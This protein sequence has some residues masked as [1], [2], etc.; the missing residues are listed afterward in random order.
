M[1]HKLA[2]N[3]LNDLPSSVEIPRYDRAALSPGI[4]HIGVGNF[5]RAHQAVYLNKLI[6][7]DPGSSDWALV[8]AGVRAPDAKM[9]DLLSD[10]NWLYSVVEVDGDDHKASIVGAMIDF[11]AVEPDGNAPLVAAMSDPSIRI[12]S[13]TVTEGGYFLD[14]E[15]KFDATETSV[16]HDIANPE[17]PNTAFGAILAALRAR[18][19][20]GHGPFTVMSCDNLPGNGDIAREA[21][22]QMA[23]AQDASFGA[24][25]DENVTFPNGMVDRI[26][27]ATGPRERKALVDEF[28][29]EDNFPVFCEPF[30]QWVMEDKFV[31]GRPA[32]EKVGVTFTDDLESFEKMKL[33]ILNGGHAIIAYASAMLDIEYAH[34]AMQHPL[35]N[36]YLRKIHESDVLPHVPSVP[37]FTPQ[38]YMELICH[39]FANPGVADTIA[40]LCYDGTNRQPKFIVDS[41]RDNVKA[42]RAPEGL[43]LSSAMW[44]RYCLGQSESGAEIGPNDPDWDRLQSVAKEA[45]ENPAAWLA[46]EHIYGPVGRDPIFIDAF[47]KMLTALQENGVAATVKA[48]LDD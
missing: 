1:A 34:E 5:H 16:A 25:V 43:A 33:R 26:T 46:Q 27:P 15:G 22:V 13:L 18:K 24:W 47:A 19:A 7:E 2:Q 35:I 28:E 32:L 11:A 37:G 42:G 36:A 39:R 30:M 41:V 17:T 4:V 48:Y 20:A 12:V 23:T 38:D 14:G 6:N 29:I 31:A 21:V 44:C 9:R 40:R 8:G 3:T 45:Q 10:Q